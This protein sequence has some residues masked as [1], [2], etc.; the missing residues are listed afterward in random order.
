MRYSLPLILVLAMS[1]GCNGGSI[2]IDNCDPCPS[3]TGTNGPGD[4]DEPGTNTGDSGVCCDG[5]DTDTGTDT[6]NTGT[7]TGSGADT[8]SDTG[9][10]P[11]PL[12]VDDD[13]DGFSENDGDCD[14]TDMW[15]NPSVADFVGDATDNNC[16]GVDG[17]D[18][19]GDGVANIPSGGDDCDDAEP[20]VYSGNAEVYYD[21][22][23]NDCDA[24]TVDDDQDADG[25][26]YDGLGGD[27]CDDTEATTH[28]TALD[29]LGDGVDNDC[30]GVDGVDNDGDGYM[31]EASG[32]GDCN[33]WDPAI[34]PGVLDTWYDGIDSDCDGASD[35]DY[36]GDGYD[37]DAYYGTDCND[38]DPLI[39]PGAYENIDGVDQDCVGDYDNVMVIFN[40]DQ[41]TGD[42]NIWVWE[43]DL[44]ESFDTIRIYDRTLGIEESHPITAVNSL[45]YLVYGVDTNIPW[46][47]DYFDV[48]IEDAETGICYGRSKDPMATLWFTS[49]I[50][51][52]GW[53]A[54]I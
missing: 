32:G 20:L 5:T 45:F 12:D 35:Y 19:D 25:Y 21:G 16:D 43:L 49:C 10:A 17:T 9:T 51:Y 53:A 24:A 47:S 37:S 38:T 39:H 44:L 31:S 26:V 27:D 46:G 14:D 52:D 50:D 40:G 22:L 30:D 23:D 3:D 11:D 8:G 18:Y 2:T 6:G 34:H 41:V 4:T 13:S 36:D 48:A 7:D 28:P 54:G 15:V 1:A 42:W 33:D 29:M